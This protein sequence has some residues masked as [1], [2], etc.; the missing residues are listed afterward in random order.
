[1][2]FVKA[3]YHLIVDQNDYQE[4]DNLFDHRFIFTGYDANDQ[5]YHIY[6]QQPDLEEDHILNI[7]E[8]KRHAWWISTSTI[9]PTIPTTVTN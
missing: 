9:W 7:T 4:D 2:L 1:M 6:S 3:P 5:Y 8:V